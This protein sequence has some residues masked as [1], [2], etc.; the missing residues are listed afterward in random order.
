MRV[1]GR[2]GGVARRVPAGGRADA[3]RGRRAAASRAGEGRPSGPSG[4]DGGQ[5]EG[6][7]AVLELLRGPRR[8]REVLV[9]EDQES[10]EVLERVVELAVERR[11]PL[12]RVGRS[13]LEARA[14][15]EAPQGVLAY[16]EPLV[17][18]T[19]DE[20]LERGSRRWP[21]FLVVVEGVTDPHNLGALLRSA[22]A[23]GATGVLLPRHRAAHVT[24]AVTKA[25]A[26][27]IEHLALGLAPGVP[28]ALASLRA[29]GVWSV[30][31]VPEAPVALQEVEL[32]DGPV[33]VVLGSE[34]RGLSRLARQRC[35][36]LAR[37]PQRGRLASINVSAAGA[38]ACFEV[39]R[40]RSVAPPASE[41]HAA[42]S[43][44]F[45]SSENSGRL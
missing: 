14:R 35:D 17:E 5:V 26:G 15:T 1:P 2:D 20:L 38:V 44:G 23:A 34:G 7:R 12:R 31:L 40:R 27:A 6:R 11:V 3:G 25:A 30:G 41:G 9:A 21:S 32:F 39:A 42:G 10:A 16:A 22:E 24:P 36:V 29:L 37:I 28:A 13:E 4:L 18:R 43:A 19:L 45:P 8:V 33:A